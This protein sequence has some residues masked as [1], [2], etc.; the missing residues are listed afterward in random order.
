MKGRRGHGTARNRPPD[1]QP[2]TRAIMLGT[3]THTHTPPPT[4]T[5]RLTL[6]LGKEEKRNR[7]VSSRGSRC[8][9]T[10]QRQK[11]KI[12]RRGTL[13]TQTPRGTGKN[14]PYIYSYTHNQT[15]PKGE[16]Q[17]ARP[18]YKGG[19]AKNIEITKRACDRHTL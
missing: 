13:G 18:Y 19:I 12:V 7:R 2:N 5:H 6:H 3:P 9:K 10:P 11:N 15:S 17:R 1:A 4:H 8:R 16:P 14:N